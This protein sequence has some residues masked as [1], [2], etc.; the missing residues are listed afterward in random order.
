ML[1]IFITK[2]L[3]E[4]NVGC[5]GTFT[6]IHHAAKMTCSINP[7]DKL[8][9]FFTL[10]FACGKKNGHLLQGWDWCI[11]CLLCKACFVAA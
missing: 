7:P 6:Q 5:T 10:I 4:T 3:F 9:I 8:V 1:R 2:L 11:S